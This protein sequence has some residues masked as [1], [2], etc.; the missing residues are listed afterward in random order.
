MAVPLRTRSPGD[1]ESYYRSDA[2]Q[3]V[4]DGADRL[5]G[6]LEQKMNLAKDILTIE[7]LK[8]SVETSVADGVDRLRGGL[9]QKMSLAK[10][11]L[12]IEPAKSSIG[13]SMPVPL[14]IRS[15]GVTQNLVI[16]QIFCGWSPMVKNKK[17]ARK[18]QPTI[19]LKDV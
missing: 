1:P 2:A 13:A 16:V 18:A 10:D 15:P 14:P 11:F 8:S 17:P 7:P 4:T 5:R 9:E 3:L 12:N 6:G 19:S